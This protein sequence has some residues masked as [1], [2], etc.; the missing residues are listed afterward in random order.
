MIREPKSRQE[1]DPH[2]M[3]DLTA[4]YE[5]ET[6]FEQDFEKAKAQA[7][8][9]KGWQGRVKEDPRAAIRCH[10]ALYET[11]ERLYTYAGL[12]RDEDTGD[13]KRQALSARMDSL[14]VK[15]QSETAFLNPE[16]LSLPDE[17]LEEMQ[18]DPDFSDFS[19]M[20][21]LL[22]REKSHIL[23]AEQEALLAAMGE[24]MDTADDIFSK[25]NDVDLPLPQVPDEEGKMVQLTHGN[26]GPLLRSRKRDVRKAAFEAMN[27]TFEKFRNTVSAAYAGS[28]KGD[29]FMA[30]ARKYESARQ[31]S[32]YPLEIPESVYDNLIA[33]VENALPAMAEYMQIRKKRLGVEELHLY[34]LYVPIVSDFDM[35]MS[36]QE[37]CELVCEGLQPLGEEYIA[38]LRQA[39]ESGWIDV[40]ENKG[41]R[42][43]AYSWGCYGAH[44]YVLLNH[45]D[46]LGG[47]MTLAHELGHA[48]HSFYSNQ[49]Q[50]FMK[51]GYSLF[52]AE[53]ASTCNEVLLMR[54]LLKK[55]EGN[56]AAKAFLLNQLLEE[57]RTTVFRQT[58]FAAFEKESHAMYE[59]GEALTGDALSRVYLALNE[60][61]YGSGCVV[62]KVIENEW[63]RIPHFY[64]NF[65]V[66]QYATGF[67][68]AVAIAGR[69]LKL[70]APAVEDYKKFLSAGCSVPPIE[71]LKYAGVDMEQPTA[72]QEAMQ[73]FADTVKQMKEMDEE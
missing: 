7:E 54:H 18:N 62:D 67:S 1:M 63:M 38:T 40:Y 29:V 4:L 25:F 8:E 52:V 42:S 10:T 58:M 46:D 73:M 69:I 65:Y 50:C 70:G 3:W 48:M 16:L 20:L 72:V 68:A 28:V 41:K 53:V 39:F 24:V 71:A 30:R 31:A 36:Y 59:R 9:V 11:L 21:R 66:Y 23:P 26:F 55:F 14:M 51:A 12:H 44:P 22:R 60:K 64:R 33:E 13:E 57:F 15:A 45:T 17:E 34:D 56:K 43:G 5:T 27:G 47:A 49:K 2:F 6:A 19:E 35:K 32:L 61:Y 37:A